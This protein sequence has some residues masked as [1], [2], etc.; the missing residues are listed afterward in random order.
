MVRSTRAAATESR[1]PRQRGDRPKTFLLTLIAVL[2]LA[3]FLSP[4][5]RSFTYAI[6]STDQIT[7]AGTPLFP[8]DPVTFPYQGKELPILLVPIDGTTREMALFE[9]G[10]KQSTFIDPAAPDLAPITWVGSWRT[11]EQTWKFAPHWE[12]FGKVWNLIDYPRLLFNTAAIALIST[13]GTLLSCTLVAYGFARFQFPGRRLLFTILIATIFLPAAVT[14]I[15]TYTIFLKL[16]WVGTWLPL[17]VPT[18]FANAFDVFLMR[19]YFMTIPPEMDEAA[20]IDGARSVPHAVV[21]HP[22]AVDPGGHRGGGLPPRVFVER[23]LRPAHLYGRQHRDPDARPR[24]PAVRRDPLPRARADPGGNPDDSDR[25]RGGVHPR[26]AVLHPRSRR[27][28]DRQVSGADRLRVAL[29]FDAEHPDRPSEAGVTER[30]LET[31]ASAG[32]RATF[33]VQGRWAEAYPATARAIATAGHLVGNHSHYHARMPLLTDA[34]LAEDIAEAGRIILDDRRGPA[35]VVPLPVRGRIGRS[36]RVRAAAAGGYRHAGWH[37][38]GRG[39]GARRMTDRRSSGTSSTGSSPMA[40]ARSRCSTP[41]PE[42]A[43]CDPGHH[44]S[45][46]SRWGGLVGIDELDEVPAAPEL[47]VSHDTPRPSPSSR[48]TGATPRRT[49]P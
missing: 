39:L 11:L 12:N 44:R 49:S 36:A 3:A 28:R 48:S 37:V 41:G 22:A 29:T 45:S 2:F 15:P 46:S 47:G 9:P 26:P 18:F 34:G 10:R 24:S 23:L 13:I 32:V 8:A 31:L 21:G 14:I 6:K 38:G 30:L 4:L 33:F 17:L 42:D 35:T 20:A 7:Q 16:G 43:R 25:P 19:Q 1:P 27:H 40:T 5:L